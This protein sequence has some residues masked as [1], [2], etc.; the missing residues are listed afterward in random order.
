MKCMTCLK[1]KKIAFFSHWIALDRVGKAQCDACS[2]L[3]PLRR[4]CL[5][6]DEYCYLDPKYSKI[7]C[8][9]KHFKEFERIDPEPINKK[10][11]NNLCC[12]YGTY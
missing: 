5:N 1:N 11:G 10:A 4:S 6:W 12:F 8:M 3:C 7:T 2:M 9:D